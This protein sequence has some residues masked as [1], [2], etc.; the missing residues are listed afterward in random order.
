MLDRD[1][2][3]R[4]NDHAGQTW[5]GNYTCNILLEEQIKFLAFFSSDIIFEHFFVRESQIALIKLNLSSIGQI[6][7]DFITLVI[8]VFAIPLTCVSDSTPID[9][10]FLKNFLTQLYLWIFLLE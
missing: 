7:A 1:F 10:N 5:L 3:Q 8:G 6:V 2:S 4:V 9:F